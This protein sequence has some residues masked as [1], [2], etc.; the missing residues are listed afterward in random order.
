MSMKR[1]QFVKAAGPVP[2]PAQSPSPA[3]AQSIA[4]GQVAPDLELPEVA[5]HDLRRG[6]GLLEAR[7]RGDRQQVPDP[8]VRRPAKSSPA[9]R[10]P[11][12]SRTAPSRCCHTASYYYVGKDPTFAF[13]TAVPFGLNSR[14]QNAW[15]YHGGGNELLNE[16][17]KKYNIYSLPGGN[18]GTPDGRL[19][20]QGD[21]DRRRPERPE[22]AHRRPRR[23]RAAEARLGAAADRRRRHLSGAGKGHHRRGRVGRPVRRRE[24]RLQQGRAV[25]LLPGL[26]GRRRRA[27]LLHQHAEVGRAAEELPGDRDGGGGLRQCRHA[28]QVRRPQP[29]RAEAARA[30]RRAAPSVLA[31]GHGRLPEGGRGALRR[32]RQGQCGL[33]EDLRRAT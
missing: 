2:P 23:P 31:R 11:T 19:V 1:R 10:P 12:P 25:L 26:V 13:G 17:Y 30:G 27:A 15:F 32:D 14:Q 21:Q 20:P 9:C 5:R 33:Q 3:I 18:T 7:G 4:G 6:R 28:G 8:G 24:A 29:R 16:F 22:D